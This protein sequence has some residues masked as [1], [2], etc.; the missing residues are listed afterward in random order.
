MLTKRQSRIT[1][2]ER[3]SETGLDNFWARY[4]SST[5]GR[6]MSPD[7]S[8]APVPV[9]YA[10]LVSPQSLNL[11]AYVQNNPITG[12]DPDGH[13]SALLDGWGYHHLRAVS[14]FILNSEFAGMPF[15]YTPQN[16]SAVEGAEAPTDASD[17]GAAQNQM[18]LSSK[19][20]DFIKKYEKL[21]L[22]PYKDQAGYET[23]GY[24][25]KILP[26][27]DFSK[28][29]T[30]AQA[31]D[32]LSHDAQGAVNAVNS[33]LKVSVKQN[34]FDALVSLAFNA[35]PVSVKS[36]NQ[37]MRAVNA[38]NVT[39]EN[40]TAYRFVHVNGQAVVSQG[41]LRRRED[42]YSMYSEGKY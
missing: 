1:G 23:I 26:G 16:G 9:P 19:G 12:I 30:K 11:Y 32:L 14:D 4:Y 20:L 13:M 42:E 35:G 17:D 41:L 5:M 7:W 10:S 40:F 25:H 8:A 15:E 33:A 29:I 27:E 24:G 3:D 36:S 34:Q 22:T 28:G 31:L 37:M 21:S 38:G 39:E 2:K 6:F 18:S